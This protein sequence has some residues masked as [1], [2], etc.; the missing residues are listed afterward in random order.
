MW[1]IVKKVTNLFLNL[2]YIMQALH[3]L[4]LLEEKRI[5]SVYWQR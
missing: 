1:I 4:L 2:G 5:S 3:D